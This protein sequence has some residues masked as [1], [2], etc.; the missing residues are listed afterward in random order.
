MNV[1]YPHVCVG[2]QTTPA[3]GPEACR[4]SASWVTIALQ[5]G[6]SCRA[7]SQIGTQ[8]KYRRPDGLGPTSA[9]QKPGGSNWLGCGG[10][11][12]VTEESESRMNPACAQGD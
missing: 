4:P 10:D 12:G 5:C 6:L 9:C 7:S 11:I 1:V 3:F 2:T 8:S